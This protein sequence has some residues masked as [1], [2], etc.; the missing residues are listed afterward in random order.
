MTPA[1][2]E[3]VGCR[4]AARQREGEQHVLGGDEGIAGLLRQLLG[5]VEHPR[6]FRRQIELARAAALDLRQLAELAVDRLPARCVG[7]AASAPSIRL[8]ARPS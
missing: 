1:L 8:A 3:H 5:L 7:A 4:R 6:G 2:L